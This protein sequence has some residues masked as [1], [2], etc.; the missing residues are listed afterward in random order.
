MWNL[1]HPFLKFNYMGVSKNRGTPKWMVKIMENPI[2]M[3]DLGGKPPIFGN[4]HISRL[5]SYRIPKKATCHLPTIMAWDGAN[6]PVKFRWVTKW[7]DSGCPFRWENTPAEAIGIAALHHISLSCVLVFH[8]PIWL[9]TKKKT[10]IPHQILVGQKRDPHIH[11]MYETFHVNEMSVNNQ[12][13]KRWLIILRAGLVAMSRMG[14]Q[15][16]WN[17]SFS[18]TTYQLVAHWWFGA[19][20]FGFLGSPYERDCCFRV[21]RLNPKAPGPQPPRLT[22]TWM[23]RDGS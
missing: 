8:P 4:S 12:H 3:D 9:T 19:Q 16:A 10:T 7:H 18:I 14:R 11:V 23:S 6:S 1:K 22:I 20:W 15:T 21:A 13:F 17:G 2:K 5:K